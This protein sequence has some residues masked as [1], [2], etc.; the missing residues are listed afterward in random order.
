MLKLSELTV[1]NEQAFLYIERFEYDYFEMKPKTLIETV[2]K[3]ILNDHS[4]RDEISIAEEIFTKFSLQDALKIMEKEKVLGNGLVEKI[5]KELRDE[6]IDKFEKKIN[7]VLKK[8]KNY[9]AGEYVDNDI[10]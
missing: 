4:P 1:Q 3:Y 10:Y 6:E 5:M 2:E 8:Y 7:E 9:I